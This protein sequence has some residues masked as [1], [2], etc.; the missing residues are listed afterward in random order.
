MI[1][2]ATLR[3]NNLFPEKTQFCE[4][5]MNLLKEQL[6]KTTGEQVIIR[7]LSAEDVLSD[8]LLALCPGEGCC[9][10]GA[11]TD[12]Y[13]FW[14]TVVVPGW[15]RRFQ[16]PKFRRFM[17][18]TLR[19]EAPSHIRLRI[20]WVSPE[21]MYLFEAAWKRWL[22]AS[23]RSDSCDYRESLSGLVN[24]LMSMRNIYPVARLYDETGGGDDPLI[25]LDETM[26][27]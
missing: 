9:S 19:K 24:S 17:E 8:A 14:A 20:I 3:K 5:V 1:A 4:D 27:G 26:V 21:D 2:S 15:P 7:P 13:S 12:P 10:E 11:M 25:V 18:D 22:A 6:V 16:T 23:Y